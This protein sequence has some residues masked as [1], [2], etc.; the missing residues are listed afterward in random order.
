[1]KLLLENNGKTF[2]KIGIDNYFLNRSPIAQKVRV[3]IDKRDCIKLKSFCTAKEAIITM[4]RQLTECKKIFANLF[5]RKKLN[6][7]LTNNTL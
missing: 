1:L 6:T 5:I 7:K 3:R 2:D 4:K